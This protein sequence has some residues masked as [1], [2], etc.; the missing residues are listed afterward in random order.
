MKDNVIKVLKVEPKKEPVICLLKNELKSLQ[1]AVSIGADHTGLIEI[2]NLDVGVCL[3]CNEEGK[4]IGLEPNRRLG[5]DIICGVFYILGEDENGV[6]KSL[7]EEDVEYYTNYF[8]DYEEISQ[9]EVDESVI[10]HFVA[11]EEE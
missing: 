8:K 1:E 9:E 10:M 3:L 2:I 4:L 7:S 11:F 5:N 6:L